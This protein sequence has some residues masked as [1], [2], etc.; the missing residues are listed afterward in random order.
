MQRQAGRKI[1][2]NFDYIIVGAGS[3]GCVLANRLSEKHS[4]LLLEAG[5]TDSYLP[6]HVP[7][8][9]LYCIDN[10]RTDYQYKTQPQQHLAGRS[11]AY[12]RGKGLGGCSSINGMIYMRGQKE[13]YDAWASEVDD[14]G[15]SWEKMLPSFLKHED[16]HAAEGQSKNPHHA[17]GGPWRVEQQRLHWPILD[18]FREAAV[19]MGIPKNDDFNTG[20]NFG[21]G[22]FDVTQKSGW[23][24]NAYQAFVAPIVAR[25]GSNLT[26][27]TEAQVASLL[28]ADGDH[29]NVACDGVVTQRGEQF[30]ANREV[31]LSSGSIGSVQILE[32]SGVGN[33]EHLSKM[34]LTVKADLPGVGENLQDHLQI[35]PVFKVQNTST[36]NSRANSLFGAASIG[37]E[38]LLHQ[39]GPMSMAPSQLGAFAHSSPLHKRPNIQFHVQPLSLDKFGDYLHKFDAVTASVC[40]LR[41]TSRG[42]VHIESSDVNAPPV[43]SPNYLSTDEDRQVAAESLLLARRIVMDSMAFKPFAPVEFRPGANV[44]TTNDLITAAAALGTTIFHPAGTCK[45]GKSSANLAVV[46]SRLKVHGVEGLR[47]VD[48]SILPSITSGNTAAPTMAIAERAAML[49]LEDSFSST[50]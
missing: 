27:L 11:L 23:R 6:I 28:F 32:R 37:L 14:E 38:Y 29:G 7:V 19:E 17:K 46:D 40:N 4:V 2:K 42:S 13:D 36:L 43:I 22:Y 26:V 5:K 44:T 21:V 12:P 49:I 3:A 10:P 9:Y 33:G 18:V 24:L 48:T 1:A 39:T 50:R 30:R 35:R 45:M 25:R 15:W 41:P 20:N 31:I 34:G 47:V 16:Y 8:G